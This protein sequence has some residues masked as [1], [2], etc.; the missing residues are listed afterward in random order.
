MTLPLK[1]RKAAAARYADTQ[2]RKIVF[3]SVRS[4]RCTLDVGRATVPIPALETCTADSLLGGVSA[5]AMSRLLPTPRRSEQLTR[6]PDRS[7]RHHR[8]VQRE[9]KSSEDQVFIARQPHP[10][11]GAV[12][13]EVVPQNQA[14]HGRVVEPRRVERLDELTAA[15]QPHPGQKPEDRVQQR[16]DRRG[17]NHHVEPNEAPCSDLAPEPPWLAHVHQPCLPVT[18]V[19]TGPLPNPVDEIAVCF[20]ESD[21]VQ[22]SCPE[23]GSMKANTEICV[24]GDVVW[25]PAAG[26]LEAVAPRT[27]SRIRRR[28]SV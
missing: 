9:R 20:L 19:P 17:A 16:H 28:S 2:A 11:D 7:D 21:R 6:G 18:L 5:Q 25:I 15:Q 10:D 22:N 26:R 8:P 23:T 27:R 4:A 1:T 12:N 13:D 3:F 24:L 14:H